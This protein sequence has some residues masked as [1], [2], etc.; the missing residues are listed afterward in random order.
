MTLAPEIPAPAD[1]ALRQFDPAWKLVAT[2]G[3]VA[4][5]LTLHHLAPL[6]MVFLISLAFCRL[7][8]LSLSWVCQRTFVLLPLVLGLVIL[9]PLVLHDDGLAWNLIGGLRVS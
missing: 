1:S 9:L 5:V 2:A 6:V 3:M 7:A 8:R 4:L